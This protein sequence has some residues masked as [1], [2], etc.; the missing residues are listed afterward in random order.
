MRRSAY[1]AGLCLA[2]LI[3]TACAGQDA[4]VEATQASDHAGVAESG[5]PSDNSGSAD[6]VNSVE[7]GA[8]PAD[9]QSIIDSQAIGA[10]TPITTLDGQSADIVNALPAPP[11]C[12]VDITGVDDESRYLFWQDGNVAGVASALAAAGYVGDLDSDSGYLFGGFRNESTVLWLS[13][14]FGAGGVSLG[15]GNY[16]LGFRT[17]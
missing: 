11:A 12:V 16:V 2:G 13:E 8:C 3:L 15:S 9:I 7:V 5:T 1:L 10:I 14:A 6:A 4:T 17:S